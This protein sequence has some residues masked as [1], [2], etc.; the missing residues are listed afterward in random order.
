MKRKL[1]FL[2]HERRKKREP[3]VH[4]LETY[5]ETLIVKV[6]NTSTTLKK[7]EGFNLDTSYKGQIGKC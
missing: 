6:K 1:T 7:Q 3:G 2:D 4:C 5:F